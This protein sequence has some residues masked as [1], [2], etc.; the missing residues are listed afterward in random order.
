MLDAIEVDKM[1]ELDRLKKFMICTFVIATAS[2]IVMFYY[3]VTF[4][5]YKSLGTN[6]LRGLKRNNLSKGIYLPDLIPGSF[7]ES[8]N[9]TGETQLTNSG[10]PTLSSNEVEIPKESGQQNTQDLDNTISSFNQVTTRHTKTEK[11]QSTSNTS[12]AIFTPTKEAG[13]NE[14]S[15]QELSLCPEKSPSLGKLCF[16]LIIDYVL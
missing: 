16:V 10:Q 4:S 14:N 13:S 3:S 9:S 12:V 11:G 2:F 15:D 7:Q 8:S 1:V 5:N 6:Y